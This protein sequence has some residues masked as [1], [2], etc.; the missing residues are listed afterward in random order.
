MTYKGIIKGSRTIDFSVL[1]GIFGML[2]Q[3]LPMI[4]DQIGDNYGLVFIGISAITIILRKLTTKP[5]K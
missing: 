1:L 2:E 4:K 3:N 5:L